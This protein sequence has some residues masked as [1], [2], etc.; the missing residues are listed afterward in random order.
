MCCTLPPALHVVPVALFAVLPAASVW[1][2][3]AAGRL[4]TRL[5]TTHT[6]PVCPAHA[7]GGSVP[8]PFDCYLANRGLKTLHIRMKEHQK[9]A[10]AVAQFLHSS[11]HVTEVFY[12]GA[13]VCVLTLCRPYEIA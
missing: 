11:P 12:P 6:H 8:S 1:L 13:C 3:N 2:L 7:A 10:M 9:N 5:L 4:G